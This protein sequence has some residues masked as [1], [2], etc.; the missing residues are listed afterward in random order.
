MFDN[1]KDETIP[2]MRR[3]KPELK[4]RIAKGRFT[5]L[6]H[7]MG[8]NIKATRWLGVYLDSGLQFMTHKNLTPEKAR[9]AEDRVR[10]LV[11][12]RRLALGLVRRIHVAAVQA[13][14][15]YGAQ[16]LWNGQTEWCEKYQR[17]INRQSRVITRMIRPVQV[18]AVIREAGLRPAL[19]LL[20]N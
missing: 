16:I 11:A 3:R 17:L 18:V 20:N 14:T 9:R 4:K 1:A 10:C 6:G 2:F 13:V 19:A 15:R 8:S 5:I 7:T 12:K